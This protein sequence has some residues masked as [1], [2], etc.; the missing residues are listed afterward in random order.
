MG[1]P[2]QIVFTA[3]DEYNVLDSAGT[4]ITVVSATSDLTNLLAQAQSNGTGPAWPTNFSA[5][6]D[7]PGY[8]F[9]LQGIPKAGDSFKIGFNTD[10]LND[11]RNALLMSDLQNLTN[12]QSASPR[13]M[14]QLSASRLSSASTALATRIL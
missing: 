6:N 10:G 7:Y 5:L 1:A 13:G 3:S 11:N 14:R 12:L 8:D 9:S 4:V 2:A